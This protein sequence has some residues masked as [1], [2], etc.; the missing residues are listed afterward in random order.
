MKTLYRY[1]FG[2]V[3]YDE[4]LRELEVGGVNV[5]CEMKPL[6]VLSVL[7][8]HNNSYL[9]KEKILDLVWGGRTGVEVVANAISKL[10]I[11]LGQE[12]SARIENQA[13][14]GYRLTGEIEKVV[15]S[16]TVTSALELHPG[17]GAPARDGFVLQKIL[18]KNHNAEVWLAQ[19][20]DTHVCRVY[21]YA[22]DA[23]R[24]PGLKREVYISKLMASQLG[25]K[26]ELVKLMDWNFSN[27][28]FFLESEYAGLNLFDWSR[29]HPDWEASDLQTRLNWFVGVV[30]VVAAAH[31]IGVL[32]KDI[33]PDNVLVSRVLAYD[34]EAENTHGRADQPTG[35]APQASA[36]VMKLA[37]FGSGGL[38]KDHL[39]PDWDQ[40]L[41]GHSMLQSLA[42]DAPTQ[43]TVFYIAP[44]LLQDQAATVA[45]DVYS[46]GVLL[47]QFVVKDF[48]RP[49]APGWE[50]DITDE[51][52]R[53]DI[54]KATD[55]AAT[56]RFSSA[57]ELAQQ[58]R[59]QAD[60][61]LV[62]QTLKQQQEQQQQLQAQLAL[63]AA[64]R[65]YVWATVAALGVGLVV[66]LW[67][68]HR[69]VVA[70]ELA[71]S[72]TQRAKSIENFLTVDLLGAADPARRGK[73][74][75]LNMP[76]LVARASETA[77]KRFGNQPRT[78]A[79]V[80]TALAHI[81]NSMS[82]NQPSMAELEKAEAA[83]SRAK[84]PP[85]DEDFLLMMYSKIPKLAM[86]GRAE[87]AMVL[88]ENLD[89]NSK[90]HQAKNPQGTLAYVAAY[91]TN[92]LYQF[93]G[94]LKEAEPFGLKA[95]GLADV[96]FVDDLSHRAVVRADVVG[97]LYRLGNF[98]RAAEILQV[99]FEPPFNEESVGRAYMARVRVRMAGI[100]QARGRLAAAQTL[101]IQ[102]R[103]MLREV[104]GP[105]DYLATVA[106]MSLAEIY[107]R[108]GKFQ[109]ALELAQHGLAVLDKT[110]GPDNLVTRIAQSNVAS[111]LLQL[112]KPAQ[113]L[114][115]LDEIT[116]WAQKAGPNLPPDTVQ[117]FGFLRAIALNDL[118]RYTQA[119]GVLQT[120]D[121]A[122]LE[123]ASPGGAW[124][125]RL[126]GELGRAWLGSGQVERARPLLMHALEGLRS[127]NMP[128]WMLQ[129]LE[130]ALQQAQH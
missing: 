129:P 122:M 86:N 128:V 82:M 120:L 95:I 24:L 53:E 107:E 117:G 32:H 5:A 106:E 126:E 119:L 9:S 113:S 36:W 78:E 34:A 20:R 114:A 100:E 33:K 121:G 94:K 56:Q 103:D 125:V 2:Q 19:H 58:V 12:T 64:R 22:I 109:Q 112:G 37:D 8:A 1:R 55:G 127:A 77:Q 116:T 72:Q 51:L 68:Y 115:L 4:E 18:G 70:L 85:D 61:R 111:V 27:P 46:L 67:M 102:A 60:R 44:E 40:R 25:E 75:N 10:R 35:T 92:L 89:K 81:Y 47:F 76:E 84:V 118:H 130:T 17:D 52:M 6:E 30:N 123:A 50:R 79:Q 90:I 71:Q 66:S 16:R 48:S 124:S 28:P 108:Q 63:Q 101:Y 42:G 69:S 43:G 105:D 15:I 38:L 91:N 39:R 96:L 80:H 26:P 97:G 31:G 104:V 11:A 74:A 93:M 49:L 14:I 65:P 99:L 29:S 62:R 7:L 57:A 3:V 45:S 110:F 54:A 13:R 59:T 98:D 21:K 87:E 83:Y 88:L 23:S 41:F 73:Q